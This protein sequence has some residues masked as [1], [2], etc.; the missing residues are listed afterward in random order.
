MRTSPLAEGMLGGA[1]PVVEAVLQRH[2]FLRVSEDLRGVREG[3]K[4]YGASDEA[5]EVPAEAAAADE[6]LGEDVEALCASEVCVEELFPL[7]EAPGDVEACLEAEE[8]A[9]RPLPRRRRR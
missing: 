7:L 9:V 2:L 5:L 1:S 4:D 3:E 8:R 6:V